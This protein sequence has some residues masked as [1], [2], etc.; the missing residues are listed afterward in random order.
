M[1]P[2]TFG[3]AERV[4]LNFLKYVDRDRFEIDP[5]LFL[6]PWEP[7]NFFETKLKKLDFKYISIPVAKSDSLD[8]FRVIRCFFMLKKQINDKPYDLIHTHGYLAD[9]LGILVS[10]TCKIPIIAT[11]HGFINEGMKLTLYNNL[12]CFA[13]KYFD[14]IV[15]VSDTLKFDLINRK[16]S[17]DKITVIENTPDLNPCPD[18]MSEDRSKL[19][20]SIGVD[21]EEILIG[22][23]GRLSPEKGVLHLLE[24][25]ILL[26]DSQKSIKLVVIGDGAQLT[27]L[28]EMVVCNNLASIVIF[29]G[30]QENINEWLTAID[31]FALPSLTEGTPMVIL[32]AMAHG[33][34]CVATSVG[35][36]PQ[37]IDSE[38]DGLLVSPGKPVELCHAMYSL[39]ED[40]SKRNRLSENARNKILNKYSVETWS[41]KI[42]LEYYNVLNS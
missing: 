25:I 20:K 4:N 5:I 28:K 9:L 36:I 8:I 23:I 42:E 27:E 19:R 10:R 33:V 13:L 26:K 6:R 14:R 1:T 31:I 32:E 16:I 22:Y 17:K 38:I 41:K 37:V 12:D 7:E 2:I 40:P 24:S 39:L 18:G 3:G 21:P 30:F 34:P 35:G 29:T 11:C 15:S